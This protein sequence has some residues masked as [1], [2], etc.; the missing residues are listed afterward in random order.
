M[1]KIARNKKPNLTMI[2]KT[3]TTEDPTIN[4]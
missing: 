3:K 1:K 2:S 4:E